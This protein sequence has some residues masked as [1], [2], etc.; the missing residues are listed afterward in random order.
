[1]DALLD[2]FLPA[3]GRIQGDFAAQVGTTAKALIDIGGRTILGRTLDALCES[4]RIRRTVVVGPEE[5]LVH[6]DARRATHRLAE[7]ATGPENIFRALDAL[8]REPEPP[9]RAV[10]VTTDLPFLS[11][12][13]VQALLD[14][15][16]PD[17]DIAAPLIRKAEFEARF[18][19]GPS[20]F[21]HLKEGPVTLGCAY[22]I[23]VEA[24]IRARPHIE[25]VFANRKSKVGMARLLGLPFVVKWLTRTLSVADVERKI[26]GVLGVRG[27]AVQGCPPEL[28]FD[29][30]D[31]EDYRYALRHQ[32]T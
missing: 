14:K 20:M 23:G 8:M 10:I 4:G 6:P 32:P 19:S 24:L 26:E 21:V 2:A 12:P 9:R 29:I 28:A 31:A 13:V 5:V 25:R 16:P 7:G 27:G 3:G 22:V 1:M 30:D 11:A 15:V 18:P 17:L